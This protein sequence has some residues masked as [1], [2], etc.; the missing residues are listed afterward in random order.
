MYKYLL[1]GYKNRIQRKPYLREKV[2]RD[3][4]ADN[5]KEKQLGNKIKEALM[6]N[7]H[8]HALS[9]PVGVTARG[10]YT[11]FFAHSVPSFPA[12]PSS[13]PCSSWSRHS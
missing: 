2:T 12:C 9:L 13:R 10:L 6:L 4:T 8:L 3:E 11:T 7:F 5:E 1:F